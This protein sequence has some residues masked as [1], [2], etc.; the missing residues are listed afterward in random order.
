MEKPLPEDFL[1]NLEE[2]LPKFHMFLT[3]AMKIIST[4]E[5]KGVPMRLLGALA[6][7]THC[8]KSLDLF[9]SSQREITDIDVM[10]IS[11][12]FEDVVKTLEEH[13][14]NYNK[15]LYAIHGLSASRLVCKGPRGT[16]D[17]FFD[18]LD[19]CHTIGF[20]DRLRLDYPTITVSDLLLEKM[21][22]VK[23]NQKDVIDTMIL[24]REHDVKET[25]DEAVNIS[26]VA[27]LLSKDWGFYYTV[28]TNLDKILGFLPTSIFLEES[29]KESIETRIKKILDAMEKEPK[30]FRWKTRAKLGPKVKWYNDVED[31]VR[32]NS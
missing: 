9:Q 21:Q 1:L 6:I 10:T 31:V 23:I 22:I 5:R 26:Y 14:Y 16:L 25:E 8:S 13:G 29:D 20:K 4:S 3:E 11:S 27:G 30:S 7:A 17:A 15:Q 28:K 24:L 12:R 2:K 18:K 32:G 19:M